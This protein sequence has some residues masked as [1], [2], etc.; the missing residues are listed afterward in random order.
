MAAKEEKKR[1]VVATGNV[2][3]LR[4]IA[5]IFPHYEVISAKQA[6]FEGEVEETGETF[7]ENSRLK[8]EAV[9]RALGC[10]ALADDSGLCA[11]AL[12]GAP[13]VYSARYAGGHGDDRANRLLLLKNMEGERNRRAYFQ[14]AIA[15]VYPDGKCLIAEGRTYGNI[16]YEETGENGFGYDCVFESEDLGKSFGVASAEEKNAVSHRFRALQKLSEM[17]KD[18]L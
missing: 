3:K 12:G 11:E 2:N 13:G 8:A 17:L 18:G 10:I 9:A 1:L 7:A 6:G 16:L 15:L 14:S 5:E 4:E